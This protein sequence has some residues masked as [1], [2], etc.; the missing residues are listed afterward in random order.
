MC[1]LLLF[2]TVA[3]FANT[4]SGGG[5]EKLVG[6]GRFASEASYEKSCVCCAQSPSNHSE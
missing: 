4:V 3:S 5:E 6:H 2:A 1:L